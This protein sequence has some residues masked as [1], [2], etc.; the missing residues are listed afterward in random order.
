MILADKIILLRKK[1]GL[2]QEELAEKMGVSRQSVSK[3]EGAQSIPELEKILQLSRLFGVTTDYLLKDEIEAEENC[4]D[5]CDEISLR[6]VTLEE[7]NVYLNERKRA[8][9]KIALA[10]FLCIISP[11]TLVI[12]GAATEIPRLGISENVMGVVG[13][14]TLFAFILA[15]VPIFI[16]CSF[17][18]TPFEFLDK[19]GSFELGYGTKGM[20]AERKAKF[21]NTYHRW[22]IIATCICI[23]SPIP[24]I[25]SAFANNDMLSVIMFA[26]T[27]IIAGIGAGAFIIV[28]IQ[29]G[30]M[31]KLLCEGDYTPEKKEKNG[32]AEAVSTAYWGIIT[33][34]FFVWSFL[35][36]DW[37]L[38]WIVFAVGGILFP[39]VLSL[40]NLLT[41]NNQ[42][43]K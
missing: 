7:A 8:S 34:T 16:H 37:H 23:F 29:M 11:L 31:D 35:S 14:T 39:A 30:S 42:K 28:G 12:L 2:S 32:L 10:T 36:N 33:A 17:K 15:S 18:N 3:W 41:K 25:T 9:F 1:N 5:S 19:K 21:Q 24:L 38:S 22:N 4:S 43:Q 27:V 6:K 20:V 40:C 13:I 26:V